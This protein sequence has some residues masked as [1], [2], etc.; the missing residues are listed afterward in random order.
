LSDSYRPFAAR[1]VIRLLESPAAI[2]CRPNADLSRVMF[3]SDVRE[4]LSTI[5]AEA[6]KSTPE[7]L[8]AFIRSEQRRWAEV[9]KAAKLEA[10]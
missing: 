6:Q 5:G 7:E 8:A 1:A 3:E 4:R 10:E 2:V 9:I